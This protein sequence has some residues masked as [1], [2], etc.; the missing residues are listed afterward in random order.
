MQVTSE[1]GIFVYRKNLNR[2]G[3]SRIIDSFSENTE[4]V[5]GLY[6]MTDPDKVIEIDVKFSDLNCELENLVSVRKIIKDI[7]KI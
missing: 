2:N 4:Q 5:C 7:K 3:F 1:E 6:L